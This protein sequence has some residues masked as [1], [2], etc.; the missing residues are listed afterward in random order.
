MMAVPAEH[1]RVESAIR[2]Y[3]VYKE[4][5]DAAIGEELLCRRETGNPND[6]YAVSVVRGTD[7]T[8]V[9]HVPRK[10]SAVCSLFL[11]KGGTIQCQVTE[12]R[13]FSADLPQGGME[14][15]CMLTF[16]GDPKE[17]AKV[18]KLLTLNKATAVVQKNPVYLDSE[19]IQQPRKK[20]KV[21]YIDMEE[22]IVSDSHDQKPWK[23]FD[24]IHLTDNDK[25]IITKGLKLTDN[26]IN[27]AQTMLKHQFPHVT[28]LHLTY[29]LHTYWARQ[30]DVNALQIIHSRGDHWLVISISISIKSLLDW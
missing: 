2:G 9:G 6:L 23:S 22:V 24:R 26:H 4:V 27:F 13:R 25:A 16:M 20:V 11:R 19:E 29:L 7:N 8:T 10:I 3:H 15:P 14:I 17:V 1:L 18:R 5:W 30:S 28:G 12:R 21:E